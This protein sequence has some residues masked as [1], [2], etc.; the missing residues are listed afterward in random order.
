MTTGRINQVATDRAGQRFADGCAPHRPIHSTDKA[1]GF[2]RPTHTGTPTRA[3]PVQR[4]T[5]GCHATECLLPF[6]FTPPISGR[7]EQDGQERKI[8]TQPTERRS[9]RVKFSR[10]A[11]DGCIAACATSAR[12][13]SIDAI[14]TSAG[15]RPT[16][17][18]GMHPRAHDQ[19]F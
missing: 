17:T 13:R 11:A 19:R 18:P 16:G 15:R 1:Q 10:L 9:Q 2:V 12:P 14:A 3:V 4:S 6:A 8:T 7:E 5:L